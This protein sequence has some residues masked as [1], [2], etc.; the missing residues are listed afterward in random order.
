[1]QANSLSGPEAIYFLCI[2][3][4]P[5]NAIVLKFFHKDHFDIKAELKLAFYQIC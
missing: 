5:V 4:W 2:F 1:M 3:L